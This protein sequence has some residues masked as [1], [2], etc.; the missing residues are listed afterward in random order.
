MGCHSAPREVG[1]GQSSKAVRMQ[2]DDSSAKDQTL[3]S[4]TFP[5]TTLNLTRIVQHH[6]HVVAEE[7]AS[8][9]NQRIPRVDGPRG[10]NR[11]IT[12]SEQD[13]AHRHE[14]AADCGNYSTLRI[15]DRPAKA[16]P[17]SNTT[18]VLIR[19]RRRH[20]VVHGPPRALK[21]QRELVSVGILSVRVVDS[22]MTARTPAHARS[23]DSARSRAC[24]AAR[25]PI[26]SS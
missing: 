18:R 7:R 3:E 26:G 6:E 25:T 5:G 22:H 24:R 11:R 15:L 9:Q 8:P 19:P 20:P 14:E 16:T 21:D 23:V 10:H 2:A 4:P 17:D 1:G 12:W 13:G